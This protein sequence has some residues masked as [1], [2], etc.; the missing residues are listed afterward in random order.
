MKIYAN[1]NTKR[2]FNRFS[3][4]ANMHATGALKQSITEPS[5]YLFL[6]GIWNNI[7]RCHILLDCKI[8]ETDDFYNEKCC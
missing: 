2:L 3:F 7:S 1:T 6:N 8:E 5:S 4:A